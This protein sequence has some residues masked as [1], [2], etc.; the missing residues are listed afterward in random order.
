M[1]TL[2]QHSRVS[3]HLAMLVAAA[4]EDGDPRREQFLALMNDEEREK[5]REARK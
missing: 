1:H 4:F 2:F 3:Y 5:A